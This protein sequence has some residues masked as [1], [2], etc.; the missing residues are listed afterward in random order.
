MK[1]KQSWVEFML[2]KTI[3]QKGWQKVEEFE[4]KKWEFSK[5]GAFNGIG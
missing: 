4:G 5:L 3:R 1:W 2:N